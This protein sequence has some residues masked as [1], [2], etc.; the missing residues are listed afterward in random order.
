MTSLGTF[1]RIGGPTAHVTLIVTLGFVIL[2]SCRLGFSSSQANKPV[3]ET[4]LRARA[5]ELYSCLQ[6]GDWAK[7]ETYFTQDSRETF[8]R[9][10]PKKQLD[11]FE[12]KSIKLE[13]EDRAQV[14][15]AV[16]EPNPL[17]PQQAFISPQTT[18]WRLVQGVWYAEL[19]PP[20][21]K[22]SAGPFGPPKK[23]NPPA[24]PPVQEFRFEKEWFGLGLIQAGK[25]EVARFPFTNISKHPVTIGEVINGC[26]CLRVKEE[27]KEYKPGE[28][29]VLEVE[30]DP[31]RL[32]LAGPQSVSLEVDVR[33]SP[34]G[35]M[36][37][38]ILSGA[39]PA[40]PEL[41]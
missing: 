6:E 2:W 41:Q 20:D 14:V 19:L 34:G 26:E 1:M 5:Q 36:T 17:A 38:L 28:R 37:R 3:E 21:P 27:H 25:T 4:A 32:A 24:P 40:P 11:G 10:V 13:K 16:P 8:R 23:P 15:V 22:A 31:S 12:I 33:S 29:G 7:A 39:L 18:S 9:F 30:F 35:G